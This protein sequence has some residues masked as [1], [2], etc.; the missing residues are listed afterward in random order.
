M[1]LHYAGYSGSNRHFTVIRE[2]PSA[3]SSG[4]LPDGTFA[5]NDY[6]GLPVD[7]GGDAK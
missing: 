7:K 4:A 2:I 1:I 5:A 6:R 3:G